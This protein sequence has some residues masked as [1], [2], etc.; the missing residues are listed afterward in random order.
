MCTSGAECSVP[1]PIW[2]WC[3]DVNAVQCTSTGWQC[4]CNGY[5]DCDPTPIIIDFRGEGF[6]LTSMADGVKFSF[7]GQLMQTSWTDKNYSNAWLVLDRNGNGVIDDAAELFGNLTPQPDGPNHN[8][9]KALAV[10][11]DPKNG[12]NGNGRIDPRRCRLF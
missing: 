11:D 3:I 10:F 4:V 2:T 8:G 6:H 9:Y 5:P 7:G 12:G 1:P